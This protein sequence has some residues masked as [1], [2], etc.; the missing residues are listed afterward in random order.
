MRFVI[1]GKSKKIN[2][3]RINVKIDVASV[4]NQGS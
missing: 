3:G 1:L 4:L 2:K